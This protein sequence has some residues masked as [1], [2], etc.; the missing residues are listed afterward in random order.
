VGHATT[1][2]VHST[3]TAKKVLHSLRV[4]GERTG[5]DAR[6]GLL[7]ATDKKVGI[8]RG[9]IAVDRGGG[10]AVGVPARELGGARS[11]ARS[12]GKEERIEGSSRHC[13]TLP[14]EGKKT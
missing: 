4:G 1:R 6:F 12:T 14:R 7:N 2:S 5:I 13:R 8:V 3:G 10:R 9:G 11:Y